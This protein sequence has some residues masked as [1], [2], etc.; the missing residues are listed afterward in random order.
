MT[1]DRFETHSIASA[2]RSE[3]FVEE[4]RAFAALAGLPAAPAEPRRSGSD[5]ATRSSG[6]ERFE[7]VVIGA[8]QSGL[9][10]G[11]EL[12]RRGMRFLILDASERVGDPW[13]RRWDS[14]RLFTPARFDALPGMRF[15]A[16]GDTFPTKD[17]M[18]DYL[19]VYAEHFGLPVR[20]GVRVERLA[21]SG[22]GYRLETSSGVIEAD[23]VVVAMANYQERKIPDFAVKLRP[24]IFQ[25]H[26][27]DYRNPG[28]LREG[29]VLIVGAGNSGAEI[30]AELAGAHRVWLAGRDTGQVPF[31]IDGLPGRVLLLRL[32]LRVLFH[33]ILTVR[34]PV[35]RRVRPKVLGI[36]GPLIR[37]KR[38]ELHALGV[39]RAPRVAGVENGLPRLEDG[40]VLD[41]DN[42]IWCTGFHPGFDWI[43]LPVLNEHGR[44]RHRSG[45]ARDVPGL[46]FVGLHFLHALSS[47]MIHGVARDAKRIAADLD[48]RR[49]GLGAA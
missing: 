20:C 39:E 30:A 46:Y 33:R 7:V 8:G 38:R 15:P 23:Q 4:G 44:P 32:V 1:R 40:R 26:S 41:V 35:A 45:V 48:A 25:I 13:R 47:A 9:A 22:E 34:T 21:R 14:L 16:P 10:V 3:P 42:V 31:R 27:A 2:P 5:R 19:E 6:S 36:G 28:Q 12:A 29:D 37:V 11:R 43:D 24:D 18:A 49:K 17:E